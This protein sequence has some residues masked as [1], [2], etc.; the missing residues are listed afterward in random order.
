M[1]PAVV[2][3]PNRVP[4]GRRR[5]LDLVDVEEVERRSRGPAVVDLI[6]VEAD[7]GLKAIVG[8]GDGDHAAAEAA[9]GKGR[10]PR[11]GEL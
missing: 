4:C 3:L 6:D 1:A 7:P 2:F 11:M 5:R 10:V 9:D 8:L